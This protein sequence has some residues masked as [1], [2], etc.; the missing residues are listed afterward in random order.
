MW[1]SGLSASLWTKWL[2]VW[3][4]VRAHAWVASQVLRMGHVRSKHTLMF[5]SLF[6]PLP[7]LLSKNKLK[8]LKK[9]N[10]YF[11]IQ[12]SLNFVLRFI[13]KKMLTFLVSPSPST[14]MLFIH[15][16]KQSDFWAYLLLE[17]LNELMLKMSEWNDFLLH[18]HTH[19]SQSQW[20]CTISGVFYKQATVLHSF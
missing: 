3:F 11:D 2:P 14:Y 17:I 4:P 6:F 10:H 20:W 8:P 5:L 13:L 12:N 15:K 16:Y 1:L 18:I 19:L 9:I 7:P